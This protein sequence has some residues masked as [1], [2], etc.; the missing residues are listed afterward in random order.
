MT[1]IPFVGMPDLSIRMSPRGLLVVEEKNHSQ[2]LSRHLRNQVPA[3]PDSTDSASLI[4]SP[5]PSDSILLVITSKVSTH[6]FAVVRTRIKRRITGAFDLIVRRGAFKPPE[7]EP[8]QLDKQ[9]SKPGTK[10]HKVGAETPQILLHD[11]ALVNSQ[12]WVLPGM[13]SQRNVLDVTSL[14]LIQG[15]VYLVYPNP[16]VFRMPLP[17]LVNQL[18]LGLQQ[19]NLAARA[20]QNLYVS[21]ETGKFIVSL[22]CISLAR[23]HFTQISLGRSVAAPFQISPSLR[24][25]PRA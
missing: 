25:T 18:R 3:P 13:H 19:A 10:N 5:K 12:A 23:H 14:T 22:L 4:L 9:W 7:D 8:K 2:P 11:P 16:S 17:D 1:R 21:P 24:P 6:R 20:W 15:W